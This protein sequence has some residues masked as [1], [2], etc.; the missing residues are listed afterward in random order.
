MRTFLSSYPEDTIME[1]QHEARFR[2][3]ARARI[4]VASLAFAFSPPFGTVFTHPMNRSFL[5]RS[6]EASD[7]CDNQW[8]AAD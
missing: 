3:A 8:Q 6:H 2:V 1:F 7:L 4:E 5:W